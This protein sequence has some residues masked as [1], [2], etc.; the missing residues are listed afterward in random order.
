VTL[1]PPRIV[2]DSPPKA[3]PVT[4]DG[5]P[6][7]LKRRPQWVNWRYDFDGKKWTKLPYNPRTRCRASSTDLLAWNS[8]EAVLKSYEAGE[9]DGVG[10]VLCSGDPYTGVDLDDC[11]DPESGEIEGWATDIVGRLDSYT[12]LSPSGKG[13]H[14]IVKGKAPAPLKRARIEMY[15]MERYFTVTGHAV[16]LGAYEE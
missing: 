16:D 13:L 10:S 6:S 7:E 9:Y 15:G 3:L 2:Q 14:V 5:I 4:P 11:R 8:F 1:P 12:E